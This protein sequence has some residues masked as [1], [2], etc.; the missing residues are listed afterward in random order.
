MR[1]RW[2]HVGWIQNCGQKI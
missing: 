1:M 2:R